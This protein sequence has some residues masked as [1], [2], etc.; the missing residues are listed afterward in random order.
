MDLTLY[1][2]VAALLLR[3][4]LIDW[5]RRRIA[6]RDVIAIALAVGLA[7]LLSPPAGGELARSYAAALA[8]TL[9]GFALGRVGGGDVKLLC[10]LAPLWSPL[11]LLAIFASGVAV[12]SAAL[13]IPVLPRRVATGAGPIAMTNTHEGLPL[14]TA[15]MWGALFW[16]LARLAHG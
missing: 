3:I 15:M 6:N 2:I 9:P 8:L 11:E 10:A 5:R 1:A 4:G 7:A 14:G 16:L 13:L 12:V